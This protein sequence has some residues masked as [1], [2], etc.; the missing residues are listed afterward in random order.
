[1]LI[2]SCL[3]L[4]LLAIKR[5][6]KLNQ[7]RISFWT[8]STTNAAIAPDNFPVERAWNCI[9]VVKWM[10]VLALRLVSVFTG[11]PTIRVFGWSKQS[12][13][14][15][16]PASR[17][18]AHMIDDKAIR[19]FSIEMPI[20]NAMRPLRRIG[21]WH[22]D[23]SIFK[24]G[25]SFVCEANPLPASTFVIDERHAHQSLNYSNTRPSCPHNQ[26]PTH[27]RKLNSADESPTTGSR[28]ENS[29]F[30]SFSRPVQGRASIM[31]FGATFA[32]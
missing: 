9:H 7:K 1:M 8:M 28:W 22:L 20:R 18:A 30:S 25:V 14:V 6:A 31:P 19:Y 2:V 3:R 12:N 27:P 24:V 5:Q 11:P 16:I 17:I 10:A 26:K 4:G 29:W 13:V 15:R 21:P 32:T 23:S